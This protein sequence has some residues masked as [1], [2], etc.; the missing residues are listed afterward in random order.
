M[1]PL[2]SY[3]VRRRGA[4]MI[5]TSRSPQNKQTGSSPRMRPLPHRASPPVAASR[6]RSSTLRGS[7]CSP[8]NNRCAFHALPASVK[9]PVGPLS[10][11]CQPLR[12]SQSL[13]LS[14]ELSGLHYSSAVHPRNRHSNRPF[15]LRSPS[16]ACC[17]QPTGPHAIGTTRARRLT[18]RSSGQHPGV[19]PGVAAELIRR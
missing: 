18:P 5:S 1:L 4:T 11:R 19:R 12:T 3:A 2:N 17:A 15:P 14:C 16:N 7:S 8:I 10:R 13:S 6:M 9:P